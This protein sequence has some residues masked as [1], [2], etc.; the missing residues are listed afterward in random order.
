VS[1]SGLASTLS[2]APALASTRVLAP[3]VVVGAILL[4]TFALYARNLNDWFV[5]DDFLFLRA[6]QTTGWGEW[7]EDSFD[8]RDPE[9]VPEF[10]QYRP[11][12]LVT[13]KLEY[14]LF[15]LDPLGYHAFN[16]AVHLGAALLFW[17]VARRLTGRD[18]TA[19]LAMAVFALHFGYADAVRWVVNGNT[20]LATACY[21]ASFLLFMKYTDGQRHGW[22]LL[23][24]SVLA[25]GAA[26]MYHA[27]AAPL[28]ALVP[29]WYFLVHRG[30]AHV[31]QPRAWLPLLP[32]FAFALPYVALQA[33]W[34]NQYPDVEVGFQV[35]WHMYDNYIRYFA[36]SVYPANAELQASPYV[37]AA[38]L[39]LAGFL[40]AQWR[41]SPVAPFAV[42]WFFISLAPD[43]VFVLGAFSR[44]LYLP[45]A[46]FAL[47]VAVAAT[48]A[49]EFF[50]A[51]DPPAALRR[52][53]PY[54]FLIAALPAVFVLTKTHDFTAKGMPGRDNTTEKQAAANR[55]L[56]TDLRRDVPDLREGATLYVVNAPF[57]L[58]IFTDEP[59]DRL[60]E[61]YYGD[62]EV[63][64]V[65]TKDEPHLD[66]EAVRARL[67]PQDRF[68]VFHRD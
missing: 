48:R 7:I 55:Q 32:F 9:P 40:L 49:V 34:R 65:P 13:F 24:G 2:R 60:V 63:R 27:V 30:L 41:W 31:L 37:A 61:L 6:A 15:E 18:W 62:V 4:L 46:A 52:A 17:F 14:S 11:L 33:W 64:S 47:M 25:M 35:G 21:L 45:G 54:A 5:A 26:L 36:L 23:A 10:H 12:Y 44:L 3:A 56:V 58:I 68:F 53:A 8:H 42:L 51:F 43:S 67:R 1:N 66:E 29:L 20:P 19:H 57:N 38:V 28:V 16:V 50:Q 39:V 59:L 22:L